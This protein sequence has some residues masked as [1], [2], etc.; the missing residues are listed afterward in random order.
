MGRSKRTGAASGPRTIPPSR[1]PEYRAVY[2]M[3]K[4]RKFLYVAKTFGVR[5]VCQIL[6]VIVPLGVGH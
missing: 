5:R 4:K 1:Q 3:I 2:D 6:E